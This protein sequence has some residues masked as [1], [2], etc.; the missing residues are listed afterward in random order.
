[1]DK[2]YLQNM[3]GSPYV[4]EGL[5]QALS[6]GISRVGK[7]LNPT[8]SSQTQATPQTQTRSDSIVKN[9]L[10]FIIDKTID[11]IIRTVKSDVAH[12]GPF[13]SDD[14]TKQKP[15]PQ[16][17]EDP[18]LTKEANTPQP[19]PQT[20]STQHPNG[21]EEGEEDEIEGEFLYNF[22]SRYR[23]IHTFSIEVGQ[24]KVKLPS[25]KEVNLK[26]VWHN[27]DFS[28]LIYVQT[29]KG[30]EPVSQALLFKFYDDQVNPRNEAGKNFSIKQIL[31]Q[32]QPNRNYSLDVNIIDPTI[33]QSIGSKRENLLRAFYATTTRK[34]MEFKSKKK[35]APT[36][37]SDD[38]GNVQQY[39][40]G[41]PVGPLLTK[42]EVKANL[43]SD[44]SQKWYDALDHINYFTK[45]PEMKPSKAESYKQYND[46][47]LALLAL[48][49]NK[50]EAG[51]LAQH[52]WK[53]LRLSGKSPEQISV[54]DITQKALK[55]S[56]KTPTTPTTPVGSPITFVKA[57]PG[58]KNPHEPET[59][60]VSAPVSK[61]PEPAKVSNEPTAPVSNAGKVEKKKKK[62]IPIGNVELD[63]DTIHWENPKTGQELNLTKKQAIHLLYKSLNF[64]K[65]VLAAGI[66]DK[67]YDIGTSRK[68]R[69]LDNEHILKETYTKHGNFNPWNKSN[70]L[71]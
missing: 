46:A 69:K 65:S 18:S 47:I 29:K 14:P 51:E 6:K 30:E 45:H 55:G 68:G 21:D 59:S 31:T 54:E 39:V 52:A 2:E 50:T 60:N 62:D 53:E 58:E 27:K 5:G 16:S 42:D 67:I 9:D 57:H 11:I 34:A 49:F 43:Y 25:G 17:W 56:N 35:N 36:L 4:E 22:A 7:F 70:F 8:L 38:D 3:V 20:T 15:L 44:D 41:Q 26:V 61:E 63:G 66:Y 12:A 71:P 24:E 37:T 10:A 32:A 64:T 28:N 33:L 13:L 1:M 19:Q 40:K 23:K 48:N